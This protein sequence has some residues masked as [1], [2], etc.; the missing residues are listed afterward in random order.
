MSGLS[1]P[2]VRAVLVGTARHRP[3]S[4]LTDVPSVD[5][6]V[7]DLAAVLTERCGLPKDQLKLLVDPRDPPEL[8]DAIAWGART[9]SDV[10]L[11]WYVG[12]GLVDT[13]GRLHLATFGSDLIDDA[14]SSIR[15]LIYSVLQQT[16]QD[17]KARSIVIVLDCCFAGRAAMIPISSPGSDHG[18][19]IHGAYLLTAVSATEAAMAPVN[20]RHTSFTGALIELLRSG[21]P[22]GGPWLSF[23]DAYEYLRRQPQPGDAPRP[24]RL[25]SG[26][27]GRLTLADNPAYRPPTRKDWSTAETAP[28]RARFPPWPGLAAYGPDDA[29]LFFGRDSKVRELVT[30]LATR[31]GSGGG[32]L[33][34]I[35]PSGAGKS[36]LLGAGLIPAVAHGGLG[37][38]GSAAWPH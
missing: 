31:L 1:G 29:H 38:A 32:P 10:L 21:D 19:G 34:V 28:S 11:V 30:S 13:E 5:A 22:A 18:L 8:A 12:H 15:A 23:D 16:V 17:T 33:V 9:A 7:R 14:N 37:I 3:G 26:G 6:T 27:V 35:G 24:N 4:R 2:G 25:M 36:S 20:A